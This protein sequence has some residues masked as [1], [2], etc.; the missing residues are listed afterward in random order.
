VIECLFGDTEPTEKYILL[1]RGSLYKNCKF[2]STINSRMRSNRGETAKE[3]SKINLK[4][5]GKK[6]TKSPKNHQLKTIKIL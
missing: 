3:H 2:N 4:R 1:L 5:V 6:P